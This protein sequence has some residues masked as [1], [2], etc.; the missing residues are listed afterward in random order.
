MDEIIRGVVR[1]NT[2]ELEH[3]S[4]MEEGRVVEVVV[5]PLPFGAGDQRSEHTSAGMLADYPEMDAYLE[6]IQRERKSCGY[7][8][9]QA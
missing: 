3:A 4:Q 8:E 7:R 2:I 5:R 1:G 6:E 9:V